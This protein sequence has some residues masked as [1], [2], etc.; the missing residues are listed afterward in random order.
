VVSDDLG[1]ASKHHDVA[2][3]AV[4]V[5][6]QRHAGAF[7]DVGK[8]VRVGPVAGKNAVRAVHR[9]PTGLGC[10]VPS[11]PTVVS[12]ITCPSRSRSRT[13]LPKS[14]DSSGSTLVV[15]TPSPTHDR[16]RITGNRARR[17]RRS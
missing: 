6:V 16:A 3:L 17:C 9:N 1:V 11:A 2:A 4:T 15:T 8:P 12:Q 14:V 10:G 13:R 5:E 7:A